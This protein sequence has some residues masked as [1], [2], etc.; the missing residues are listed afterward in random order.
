M[1]L[2][3]CII[4]KTLFSSYMFPRSVSDGFG[5]GVQTRLFISKTENECE[6]GLEADTRLLIFGGQPLPEPRYMF[7]NFVSSSKKR[8]EQAK[9]DWKNKRFPKVPNDD[10]YIPLK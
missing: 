8:I 6:I 10:T 7:W 1:L 2:G 5:K 4:R 3:K 9:D